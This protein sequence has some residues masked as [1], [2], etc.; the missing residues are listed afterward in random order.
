MASAERDAGASSRRIR[1]RM[2]AA[3]VLAEIFHDS[4]SGDDND[5]GSDDTDGSKTESKDD[6]GVA[7]DEEEV[8]PSP[9]KKLKGKAVSNK[10]AFI[11]KSK[12][13]QPVEHP[14]TGQPGI[15]P[16]LL[17][18]VSDE[19]TPIDF[20]T[21]FLCDKLVEILVRETNRYAAQYTASTTL[22][23]DSRPQVETYYCFRNETVSGRINVD[24][25]HP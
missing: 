21:M 6:D 2:S 10:P 15:Y 7:G 1:R 12:P 5:S 16:D 14:F 8:Q 19:P 22:G 23:P 24:G 20:F 17:L 3:D 25:C 13:V 9:A 4:D 11:W 18:S